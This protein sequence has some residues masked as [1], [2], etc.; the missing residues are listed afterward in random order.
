MDILVNKLNFSYGSNV[1]LKDINFSF[2]NNDGGKVIGIIGP[3]GTGKSSLIRCMAGFHKDVKQNILIDDIAYDN[4]DKKY[5]TS[6]VSYLP[7]SLNINAHLTAFEI[8][9]LAYKSNSSYRVKD[10]DLKNVSDV[11]KYLSIEN[12]ANKSILEMSGGQ[13][14]LVFLAKSLL[15]KKPIMLLDEPTSALDIYHQIKM[16]KLIAKSTYENKSITFVV[17]HD[18]NLVS[19]FCD[20]VMV[21]HNSTISNIGTID[22]VFNKT[23]FKNVYNM[24]CYIGKTD[25]GNIVIQ[26]EDII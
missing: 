8:V 2:N 1:I 18:L 10:D 11:F 9:L 17:L 14:Q 22:E 21:L 24:D 25:K 7:Q 12:L 6:N 20:E 3:N 5:I 16:M 4:M 19:R 23:F 26:A 15:F 13:K